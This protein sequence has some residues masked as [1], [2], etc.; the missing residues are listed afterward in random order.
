[1]VNNYGKKLFA[2]G[3]LKFWMSYMDKDSIRPLSLPSKSL[4]DERKLVAA[5][6][7]RPAYS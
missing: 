6:V 5:F 3:D 2:G 1:M 7:G 4:L